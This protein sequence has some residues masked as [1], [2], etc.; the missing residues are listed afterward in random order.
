MADAEGGNGAHDRGAERE[1]NVFG[2]AG[3]GVEAFEQEGGDEAEQAAQEQAG[4]QD[5]V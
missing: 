3:R 5:Q 4:D 1:G 2:V